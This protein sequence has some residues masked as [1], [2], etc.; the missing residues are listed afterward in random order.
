VRRARGFSYVELMIAIVLGGLMIAGMDGIFATLAGAWRE[1]RVTASRHEAARF[2]LD[3]MRRAVAAAPRLVVPLADDPATAFDE[4][5]RSETV[6]GADTALLAVALDPGLDR[7]GDGFADADNDK[8][9]RVD[10]DWPAD[11]NGDGRN[12]IRAVDD[13][14]E[15]VAD[16]PLLFTTD[17]DE[18]GVLVLAD[19]DEDPLDGI[20]NDG[21]GSIDEDVGADMNGDGAPGVAGVDDDGDGAVDEGAASDDDEDGASDEDWLDTVVFYLSGSDLVRRTPVPWD[22]DA[23]GTVTG[24]DYVESVLAE[25]VTY[26]SVQRVGASATPL[27]R[28]VLRLGGASGETVELAASVRVGSAP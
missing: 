10:E 8:D 1:T 23:S 4:S 19:S 12:G 9:G 16:N 6:G 18:G 21:D 11:M 27:V 24:A 14:G 7:D 25:E 28:I 3:D 15:G 26:F 2:A 20:D 13:R 22:V 17:D 5:V